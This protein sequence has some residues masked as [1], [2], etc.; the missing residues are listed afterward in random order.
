LTPESLAAYDLVIATDHSCLDY[1]FILRHAPL[2]VDTR[3]AIL[4][5]NDSLKLVRA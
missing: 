4:G 5:G 2:V 3:N 1:D